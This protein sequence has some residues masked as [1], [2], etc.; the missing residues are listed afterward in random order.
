MFHVQNTV[1]LIL[2][3][4]WLPAA[5]GKLVCRWTLQPALIA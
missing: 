4:H 1:R 5:G 3:C 2:V